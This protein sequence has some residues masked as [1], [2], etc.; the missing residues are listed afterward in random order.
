MEVQ[1]SAPQLDNPIITRHRK[2]SCRSFSLSAFLCHGN[3]K[4]AFFQ[5]ICSST[6]LP[7]PDTADLAFHPGVSKA[8]AWQQVQVLSSKTCMISSSFFS[9]GTSIHSG[10]VI[11]RCYS[12]GNSE[13][14]SFSPPAL[15]GPKM[16]SK[17][18]EVL[19][20]FSAVPGPQLS[21][22]CTL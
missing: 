17:S 12:N 4:S 5:A 3:P 16:G 1:K 10:L 15:L 11:G 20:H 21:W 6:T 22:P 18:T 19:L 8:W 13:F 14:K 9:A 2:Y 7:N